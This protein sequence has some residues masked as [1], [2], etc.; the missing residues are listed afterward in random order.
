MSILRND[1]LQ[2]AAPKSADSRY[3]NDGAGYA[4]VGQVNSAILASFRHIGLTVNIAGVEYWYETGT[5]DPDLVVKSLPSSLQNVG[6]DTGNGLL[7]GGNVAGDI[8]LTG[9]SSDT[10]AD[11]TVVLQGTGTFKLGGSHEAN[12]T[13]ANDVI[14]K[15]YA[16]ANYN[17]AA[18]PGGANTQLQFNN[19]GAFGAS[20]NLTFA[21]D[22]L[23][24]NGTQVSSSGLGVTGS[25][26]GQVSIDSSSHSISFGVLSGGSPSVA[27]G[28]LL[29]LQGNALNGSASLR[30]GS[31]DVI[32]GTGLTDRLTFTFDGRITTS[33]Y[34]PSSA[35]TNDLATIGFVQEDLSGLSVDL[36]T[37]TAGD[38]VLIQDVSDSNNLKAVTAQ[39][40]ADLFSQAATSASYVPST[41]SFT[42]IS[43]LTL[44]EANYLDVAG[45]VIASQKWT[46]QAAAAGYAKFITNLPLTAAAIENVIGHGTVG[47]RFNPTESSPVHV[48]ATTTGTGTSI[49]VSFNAIGTTSYE[50]SVSFFYI[51]N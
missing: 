43:T 41:G 2:I 25:N 33:N 46:F 16:D 49:Q 36:E 26:N 6:D 32:I 10:N 27:S 29:E 34:T 23:D 44:I 18:S 40:V 37:A 51:K 47:Q 24:V 8:T 5:T 15:G 4:N 11:I 7:I 1:S 21:S 22:V 14:T 20:S 3:D 13:D 28:G 19:A 45:Y 30:S 39:S 17:S 48:D 9:N 50:I 42:N 12:I 38:R 35:N 31:G